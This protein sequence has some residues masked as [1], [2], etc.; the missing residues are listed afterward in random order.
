MHVWPITI[1][2][3]VYVQR[4]L[5]TKVIAKLVCSRGTL[6]KSAILTQ[7]PP[8]EICFPACISKKLFDIE[9]QT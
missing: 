9:T 7:K 6:C 3:R 2:I 8:C 1:D 4:P 5:I